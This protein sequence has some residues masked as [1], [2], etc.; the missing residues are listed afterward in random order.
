MP[1]WT[2]TVAAALLAVGGA[3]LRRF[4]SADTGQSLGTRLLRVIS[5]NGRLK[6]AESDLEYA[7]ASLLFVRAQLDAERMDN[8]ELMAEVR[9]LRADL[10]VHR[11][12]ASTR[13]LPQYSVG[14][15]R[16]RGGKR[17]RKPTS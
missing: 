9:R 14:S 13:S 1:S 11:G 6:I 3:L 8:R 5:A 17:P 2:T 4:R 15:T 16:R 7:K 12:T 10:K